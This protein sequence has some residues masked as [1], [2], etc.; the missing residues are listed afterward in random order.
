MGKDFREAFDGV[1][2]E[3]KFNKELGLQV[4]RLPLKQTTSLVTRCLRS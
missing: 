1:I 3:K 2:E 4:Y